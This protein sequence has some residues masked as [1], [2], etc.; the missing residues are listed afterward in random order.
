VKAERYPCATVVLLADVETLEA[1]LRQLHED[2][3][4][5]NAENDA[6][7]AKMSEARDLLGGD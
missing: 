3:R 2:L 5:V 6:L 7:R 1:A 4:L